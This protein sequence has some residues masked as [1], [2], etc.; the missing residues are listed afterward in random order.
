MR[1]LVVLGFSVMTFANVAANTLDV[2]RAIVAIGL[3][4]AEV[5]TVVAIEVIVIDRM[6]FRL[7]LIKFGALTDKT[8]RCPWPSNIITNLGIIYSVIT[9]SST[10]NKIIMNSSIIINSCINFLVLLFTI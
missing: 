4:C 5:F 7:N 8:K 9:N 10:I 2:V 1:T 6:L 3:L